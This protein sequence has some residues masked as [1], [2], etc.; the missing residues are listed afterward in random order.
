KADALR[1]RGRV[2][3]ECDGDAGWPLHRLQ[4]RAAIDR[5][6]AVPCWRDDGWMETLVR[7]MGG[8]RRGHAVVRSPGVYRVS[9]RRVARAASRHLEA[10]ITGG[11]MG[12]PR[13]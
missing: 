4:G 3:G 5:H 7:R 9:P 12:R 13:G 10:L 6:R 2:R 1:T 8:T 11:P